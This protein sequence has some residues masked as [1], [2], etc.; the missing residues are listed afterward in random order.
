MIRCLLEFVRGEGRLVKL[1]GGLNEPEAEMYRELLAK[2]GIQ[3]VVKNRS[4]LAHYR[5][6][7]DNTFELSVSSS[8]ASDAAKLLEP[9]LK[10]E[11]KWNSDQR[12][13]Q[14]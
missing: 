13:G 4:G 7:L 9:W 11:E 14:C 2:E 3:I 5:I 8:Q 12:D 1:A 6:S 10:S